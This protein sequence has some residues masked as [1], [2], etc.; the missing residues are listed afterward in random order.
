MRSLLLRVLSYEG[1]QVEAVATGEHRDWSCELQRTAHLA[2]LHR[3]GQVRP[4]RHG[5]QGQVGRREMGQAAQPVY[6]VER[7]SH[8][9]PECCCEYNDQGRQ[10]E[11]GRLNA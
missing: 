11:G 8:H 1:H 5:D 7:S 2:R 10:R 9:R 4:D 6:V 3:P